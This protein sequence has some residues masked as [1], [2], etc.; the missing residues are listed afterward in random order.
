ML[1]HPQFNPA[2]FHIGSLPIRWYALSYIAAFMLFLWLGRLR[3]RRGGLGARTALPSE[4]FVF[5]EAAPRGFCRGSSSDFQAGENALRTLATDLNRAATPVDTAPAA[6]KT[7]AITKS[8]PDQPAGWKGLPREAGM[9]ARIHV[10]WREMR[11]STMMVARY[12]NMLMSWLG[13]CTPWP[14]R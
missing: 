12:G 11:A 7:G 6:T 3:I 10:G 9:L 8:P 2:A 13:H 5:V 14:C 1:I 4:R